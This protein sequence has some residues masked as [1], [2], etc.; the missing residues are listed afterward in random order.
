MITD[1]PRRSGSRRSEHI[2]YIGM[3]LTAIAI[4]FAGFA[5]TYYLRPYFQPAQ[6]SLTV[7]VHGAA[8][9]A[10]VALLLLQTT[11][12]SARR[13]DIHRT[14]G[15]VG[16]A[17]AAFMV[18]IALDTAVIAVHQAV[19]CCDAVAARAFLAIPIADMMVFGTLVGCAIAW[20]RVAGT[21][22]RLML[23]ATLTI[24]DAATSRWP[25]HVIQ[26]T[27]WGSYVAIDAVILAAVA[28]DTMRHRRMARAYAWGVPLV[29]GAQVLRELV[30][31]THAWQS[32]ARLIVG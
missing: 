8:F 4:T 13:T 20:R 7:H 25:L 23:L 1:L 24:L 16:A 5:R 2:F 6:L 30:G 10:W 26:T 9:T 17:L 31:R 28:Y 29:V 15:W 32:F 14:L 18:V 3:S 19:V 27:K 12:V 22:K 21:H 11:L